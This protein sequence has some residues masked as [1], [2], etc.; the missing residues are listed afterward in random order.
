[1]SKVSRG[2]IAIDVDLTVVDTL[3]PWLDEFK[4]IT[5]LEVKNSDRV[6]SLEPEMYELIRQSGVPP[7]DPMTFWRDPSLYDMLTPLP[8]CVDVINQLIDAGYTV[9]FVS[10]CFSAHTDSKERFLKKWFP[11]HHGFIS[12]TDKHFVD[13]LVLIDD[14][15]KHMELGIQHRPHAHHIM[16]TGVRKDGMDHENDR[17][18]H[19]DSW[20]SVLN[21]FFKHI[22]NYEESN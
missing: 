22:N 10:S 17:F 15:I 1:M 5:G 7:F 14:R 9:I 16:F 2:V 12:T 11:R 19:C 8:G 6:Y 3:A 13:Y 20:Q 4:Y 21:F 18:N